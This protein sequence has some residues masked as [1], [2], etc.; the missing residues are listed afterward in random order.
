MTDWK[1]LEDKIEASGIRKG[2]FYEQVGVTRGRWHYLRS[3]GKDPTPTEIQKICDTLNIT[4]LREKDSI[5][6]A[7]E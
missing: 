6:F 5:F 3:R 4:S 7:K 2:F 1:T